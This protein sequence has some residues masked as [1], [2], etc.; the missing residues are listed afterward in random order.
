MRPDVPGGQAT[1]VQGDDPLVEPVQPGLALGHD[2]RG[3]AARPIPRHVEVHGPDL[4]QQRLGRRAVTA[5]PRTAPGRVVLLIPEVLGH[6]LGKRPF[7][8]G[9]GH[10]REQPVRS[11]QL[12]TLGLGLGQQLVG[13]LVI[14]Q[15]LAGL[16]LPLVRHHSSFRHRVSLP[17]RS[18]RFRVGPRHLHRRSDTP[19]RGR[20]RGGARACA[21][22]VRQNRPCPPPRWNAAAVPGRQVGAGVAAPRQASLLERGE[23]EGPASTSVPP[24]VN[25]GRVWI[26]GVAVD[27]AV[28]VQVADGS[29][30]WAWCLT[31]AA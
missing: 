27:E 11:Q 2:P 6:L 14:D 16:S 29:S 5:V 30:P 22:A 21:A 23:L 12:S 4:G 19:D 1:A 28:Q 8:H 25:C 10:R 3:E 24:A 15:R 20:L 31:V 18:S 13:Q 7:Q 9:L 26:R 17:N